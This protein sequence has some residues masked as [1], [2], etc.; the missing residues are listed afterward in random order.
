MDLCYNNN[1]KQA[2]QGYIYT[3]KDI[4]LGYG[5]VLDI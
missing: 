1:Y 3:T 5:S 2:L 4:S